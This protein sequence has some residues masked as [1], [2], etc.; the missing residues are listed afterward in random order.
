MRRYLFLGVFG[1]ILATQYVNCSSYS[2]DAY[3]MGSSGSTTNVDTY[4]GIRVL[5]GTTEMKCYEDHIDVGGSCNTADSSDNFIQYSMTRDRTAV[6]WGTLA[7]PVYALQL[8]KCQ[9]GRFFAIIP[10]PYDPTAL[11]VATKTSV[12]YQLKFQMYTTVV[13]KTGYQAGEL[14]N[15]FT[16]TIQTDGNCI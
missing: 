13:G 3:Q 12:E 7:A 16:F 10:K 15:I 14:G 6:P 9:N 8:A 1:F 5:N 2:D 4:Q 11:S